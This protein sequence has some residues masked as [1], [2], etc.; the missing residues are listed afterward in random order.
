MNGSGQLVTE[1]HH[2][3]PGADAQR[4][5]FFFPVVVADGFHFHVVTEDEAVLIQFLSYQSRHHIVG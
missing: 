3:D 2:I 1:E 5:G 4:N